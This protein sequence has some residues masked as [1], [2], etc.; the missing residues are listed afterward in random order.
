MDVNV[1]GIS[2]LASTVIM[3]LRRSSM[4]ASATV[5]VNL[6]LRGILSDAFPG[7][8]SELRIM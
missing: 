7:R 6:N 5:I 1:R 2:S 8:V 4:L 3:N